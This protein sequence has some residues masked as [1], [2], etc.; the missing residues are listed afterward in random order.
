MDKKWVGARASFWTTLPVKKWMDKIA[1][2][3]RSNGYEQ[4]ISV[5]PPMGGIIYTFRYQANE[6]E[7]DSVER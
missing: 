5:R 4:L 6:A 3:V 1:R 2:W 7:S